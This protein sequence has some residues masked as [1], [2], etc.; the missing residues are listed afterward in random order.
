ME[1][2]NEKTNKHMPLSKA[3]AIYNLMNEFHDQIKKTPVFQL[4]I[5]KSEDAICIDDVESLKSYMERHPDFSIDMPIS[6]SRATLLLYACETGVNAEVVKYLLDNNA[7]VNRCN[8]FGYNALMLLIRNEDMDIETKLRAAQ[9]L[10][11]RGIDI[12]WINCYGETALN[13]ALPRI[14]PHFAK[15][16]IDNGCRLTIPSLH[17]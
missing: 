13:I 3:S 7:E 2:S 9:L 17:V 14:Q 11:D 15:L 6:V 8:I 10:I 1:K 5:Y 12:N 4:P 16:L